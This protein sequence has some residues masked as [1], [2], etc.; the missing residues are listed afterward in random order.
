MMTEQGFELAQ[1]EGA[2][3]RRGKLAAAVAG[4]VTLLAIFV[5]AVLPNEY[6][7]ASTLLIEPQSISSRLVESN[8]VESDLNNR[9]HLIQM[10]I[11][12]RGRLSKVI[13]DLDVYPEESEEMTREEVIALMRKKINVV[14][15]LPE[16]EG[17][18]GARRANYQI[19]TFQLHYRHT[20]ALMAAAVANRLARDFIDEHLKDRVQSSGD[21]SE[22]IEAE[23]ARLSARMGEVEAQIAAIKSENT[24]QLPEDMNANQHLLER[25]T[26]AVRDAQRNL[27]LAQSDEAFYRQ[28]VVTGGSEFNRYRNDNTP[29]GRLEVLKIQLNEYRARGFTDKHP[30]IIKT[31]AE[32]AELERTVQEV[33]SDESQNAQLSISQQ[34][35]HSEQQRAAL[36]AASSGQD[37]ERMQAQLDTIEQR[38][39]ATPRVA[40]QLSSLEREREHLFLSFQDFST[41]RLEAGVAASMERRQKGEK[42]RLLEE[43]IA[44]PRTASPNRLVI[45]LAGMILGLALGVGAGILADALDGSYHDPLALQEGLGL[46]VLA[47]VPKVILESDRS[48]NRQRQV[49]ELFAAGAITGLVLFA[50]VAGNWIV[51]GPPS[52]I[53]DVFGGEEEAP[54]AQEATAE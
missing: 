10:Q 18:A 17:Q 22:F 5:A 39:A 48:I 19:N 31:R 53:S 36:R 7:A 43:A 29:Q 47:S 40:E 1:L 30:D 54:A 46:P 4:A 32:V 44:D 33:A 26:S 27:S 20:S 28:Q 13:D 16:M 38:L 51:N 6:G 35:A 42:F 37:V 14:P 12:S 52:V 24:G 11:L 41:R 21:T 49:R 50:S 45:V 15:L 3:R 2:V 9:L 25:L 23:L 34:N 8:L